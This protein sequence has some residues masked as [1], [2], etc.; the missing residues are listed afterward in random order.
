MWDMTT[1][2]PCSQWSMWIGPEV[3]I[4]GGAY[5]GV[6]TLFVR[7]ATL[8]Q[9]E[10]AIQEH[11]PLRVWFCE[12]FTDWD[13]IRTI[14]THPRRTELGYTPNQF[15]S[16]A[17][18]LE[19]FNCAAQ[20]VCDVAKLHV[21]LKGLNFKYGDCIHAG[22]AFSDECFTVGEGL[23]VEPSLYVNDMRLL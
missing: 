21:K 12:E 3:E 16:K 13:T 2:P 10:S 19:D 22:P 23:K 4:P 8:A 7:R 14:A 6:R 1:K 11:K 18:F 5:K 20:S 9:I 17:A 15:I